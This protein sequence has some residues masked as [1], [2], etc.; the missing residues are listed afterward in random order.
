[1]MSRRVPPVTIRG[2]GWQ[3]FTSGIAECWPGRCRHGLDEEGKAVLMDWPWAGSRCSWFD[4]LSV[5]IDARVSDPSSPGVLHR[6]GWLEGCPLNG[7][8][9]VRFLAHLS[10][11]RGGTYRGLLPSSP[12]AA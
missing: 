4:A 10:G 2:K 9:R 12:W 3:G 7:L 1:M 5:L 11:W 6:P 8:L